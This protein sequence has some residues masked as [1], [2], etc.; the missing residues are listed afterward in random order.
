MAEY[1]EA[2]AP[3]K[4][5]AESYDPGPV[6]M[7]VV[8][9]YNKFHGHMKMGDGAEHKAAPAG[10]MH[11]AHASLGHL[12]EQHAGPTSQVESA[13]EPESDTIA[14]AHLSDRGGQA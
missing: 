6:E 12:L 10:S 5:R 7:H 13:S 11:E 9:K 3:E 4:P 8:K 1:R 14:G 2:K